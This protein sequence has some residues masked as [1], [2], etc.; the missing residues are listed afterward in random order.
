MNTTK[1]TTNNASAAAEDAQFGVSKTHSDTPCQIEDSP[2]RTEQR[3]TPE[4]PLDI[5]ENF[6]DEMGRKVTR[7]RKAQPAQ[8]AQPQHSPLPQGT[9][10]T[11]N[12]YEGVI[13]RHYDG[14]MY[15]IR[16]PGG[17][18]CTDDF[19][20]IYGGKF[21][22]AHAEKLD[23]LLGK[24][25]AECDR[26]KAEAQEQ[27]QSADTYYEIAKR[28]EAQLGESREQVRELLAACKKSLTLPLPESDQVLKAAIASVEG[29]P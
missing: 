13:V 25:A 8:P 17:V 1:P 23:E 10:V 21:W 14:N 5:D 19:E 18:C 15:E 2:R 28:L 26:L 12:G 11:A 9:P 6:T 29:K 22:K 20:L 3:D 4:T 27:R 7:I 16:L 24:T